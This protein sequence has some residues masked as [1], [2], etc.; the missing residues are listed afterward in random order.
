MASI[1]GKVFYGVRLLHIQLEDGQ[2]YVFPHQMRK[3]LF[4]G[5]SKERFHSMKSRANIKEKKLAR[6]EVNTIN[7]NIRNSGGETRVQENCSLILLNDADRFFNFLTEEAAKSRLVN[8]KVMESDSPPSSQ[9]IS[10]PKDTAR[11]VS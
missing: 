5:M 6:E 11:I 4:P 2:E 10:R 7:A 9:E 1:R 8:N 3:R